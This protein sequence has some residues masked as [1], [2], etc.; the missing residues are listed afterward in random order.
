M[1]ELIRILAPNFIPQKACR[2]LQ[3]IN[4]HMQHHLLQGKAVVIK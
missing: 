1:F 3:L 4:V 2:V